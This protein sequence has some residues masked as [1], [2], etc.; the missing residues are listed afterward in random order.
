VVFSGAYSNLWVAAHRWHAA[1]TASH[2]SSSPLIDGPVIVM[3]WSSAKAWISTVT[4][5][6][7]TS[8]STS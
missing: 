6:G 2:A 7:A 4:F 8:L 3:S 5:S 1:Q